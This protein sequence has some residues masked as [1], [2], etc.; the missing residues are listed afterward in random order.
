MDGPLV[1]CQ[2][3]EDRRKAYNKAESVQSIAVWRMFLSFNWK[4]GTKKTW[5]KAMYTTY[6]T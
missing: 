6:I 1:D 3:G 5:K 4:L 2:N